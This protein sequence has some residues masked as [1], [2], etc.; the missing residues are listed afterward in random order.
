MAQDVL[1]V[2]KEKKKDYRQTL[3][4]TI[5]QWCTEKAENTR[6]RLCKDLGMDSGTLSN[7]ESRRRHF[8]IQRLEK[9]LN[10]IGARMI[11]TR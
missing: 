1:L 8:S 11:L 6:Y 10:A 3:T 9:V 4:E 2:S 5:D 7:V